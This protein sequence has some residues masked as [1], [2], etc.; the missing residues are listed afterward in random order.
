[1]FKLILNEKL[2]IILAYFAAFL[3]MCGHASS[4]FFVKLSGFSGIEVTIWK[5]GLGSFSLLT[6]SLILS[7]SRDL[8][9]QLKKTFFQF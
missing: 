6:L 9:S 8:I 1:M 3:G 4:E 7:K 2:V 5:F